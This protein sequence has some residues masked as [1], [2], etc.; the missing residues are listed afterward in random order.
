MFDGTSRM[1]RQSSDWW[2][3]WHRGDEAQPNRC[4]LFIPVKSSQR[5]EA[6]NLL[7]KDS[8]LENNLTKGQFPIAQASR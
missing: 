5:L 6:T 8:Q 1:E 2:H 7:Y 3:E 4:G